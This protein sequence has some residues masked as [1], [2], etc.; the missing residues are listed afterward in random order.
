MI[1]NNTTNQRTKN[2]VIGMTEAGDAGWD[3]SWYDTLINNG[4][5]GAI[6]ITKASHRPEFQEKALKLIKQKPCIIHAG[7][8]G[9]GS[10]PMEPGTIPYTDAIDSIRK[11]IDAGFPATNIV[12]RIDP[13][14]PTDEGLKR[15]AD[16]VTYANKVIPDVVR[17]RISIYDDYHASREEICRRGYKPIDNVTRWKNEM[18]RRPSPLQVNAVATTLTAVA[19]PS[20]IFELC[21]E[22]ELAEEYP[23]RF[24]WFGCLSHK[25]CEI[26]GITVPDGIGINGQNRFGCR[27]LKLKR[28]LLSNK[29]RCPNNCAY[30]Y[31]GRS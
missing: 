30:C 4:Y 10:T 1:T 18:Q 14:I 27:C 5:A 31:W 26:M 12:L 13:I 3:L 15:A 24:K 20:T 23:D 29:H 28:E 7:I 17:M 9:W 11:F 16:V 8:T 19:N 2:P 25:D 22:P 6:L 21:A